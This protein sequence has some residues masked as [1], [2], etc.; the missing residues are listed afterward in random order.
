MQSSA[1]SD[2]ANQLVFMFPGQGSQRIG[3]GKELCT[4]YP[5][6]R[7]TYFEAAS[8]ILGF[9]MTRLCFEGPDAALAR[10]ENTQPALLVVSLAVLAAL[11]EEGLEPAVAIGHSLG[12][13][14]ALVA[15]GALDFSTALRLVRRRGEMMAQVGE[16]SQGVMTAI[17]GLTAA[18]LTELCQQAGSVGLVEIANYNEPYQSVI[19]GERLAVSRVEQLAEQAG[20]R[21]IIR[22]NVSAP[23][24]CS[25]MVGLQKAF[26]SDL[27]RVD[28]Q[29]PGLPVLANVSADYLRT[30]A[31]VRQALYEQVAAP[32]RWVEMVQRLSDEGYQTF[33]EVGPGKVLA[34]LVRQIIP[35][36]SRTFNIDSP[37]RLLDLKK[38]LLATT[39]APSNLVQPISA[40]AKLE[41]D[42]AA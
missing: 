4:A 8:E 33:V 1:N 5:H 3:M 25:L 7:Q 18:E 39:Y 40:L 34:G 16:S 15:A 2:R 9:D 22:L 19:S 29:A 21:A 35:V 30:A 41:V 28:F 36:G 38:K 42:V 24:H 10:T 27:N 17:I 31:E 23:F 13:Y 32:V 20:A 6:L 14:A 12:E 11:K 37:A 26:E